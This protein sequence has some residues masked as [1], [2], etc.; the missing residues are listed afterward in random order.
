[1]WFSKKRKRLICRQKND[2]IRNGVLLQPFHIYGNIQREINKNLVALRSNVLAYPAG[3]HIVLYN[4]RTNVQHFIYKGSCETEVTAFN[5][6]N[7]SPYC[8]F[9]FALDNSSAISS[10]VKLFQNTRQFLGE[11]KHVHVG[12]RSKI[13]QLAFSASEKFVF[14][15]AENI[16]GEEY[17]VSVWSVETCRLLTSFIRT[18]PLKLLETYAYSKSGVIY[19]ANG[20]LYV[21]KY[22][23][24]LQK[25]IERILETAIK[26]EKVD[27]GENVKYKI[28][29]PEELSCFHINYKTDLLFK[30]YQTKVDIFIKTAFLQTVLVRPFIEIS[31]GKAIQDIKAEVVSVSSINNLA[32]IGLSEFSHL[33]IF[34]LT[35]NNVF[36][37]R[38]YIDL[39]IKGVFLRVLRIDVAEDLSTIGV[40]IWRQNTLGTTVWA[41]SKPTIEFFEVD[42]AI[43]E[44]INYSSTEALRPIYENGTFSGS[45]IDAGIAQNNDLIVCLGN[46]RLL[47]LFNYKNEEEELASLSLLRNGLCVDI[48]PTGLQLAVGFKEGLKVFSATI[49]E[50]RET[51]EKVGKECCCVRY[52]SRGDTLA[53]SS[54]GSVIIYDPFSMEQIISLVAHATSIKSMLWRGNDS[55]LLTSCM[56]GNLFVWQNLTWERDF[57]FY[58]ANKASAVTTI[59]YDTSLDL[60]VYATSN[61]KLHMFYDKGAVEI[62]HHEVA[63]LTI[64]CLLICRVLKVLFAGCSNGSVQMFIWPLCQNKGII[65]SITTLL[66]Q[67]PVTKLM[68]NGDRSVLT[69]CSE[70]ATVFVSKIHS[71]ADNFVEDKNEEQTKK[72]NSKDKESPLIDEHLADDNVLI[73][74]GNGLDDGDE[75]ER[76]EMRVF[77]FSELVITSSYADKRKQEILKDL[78]FQIQNLKNEIEEQKEILEREHKNL[79]KGE[80]ISRKDVLKDQKEML[81]QTIEAEEKKHHN[82]L[83]QKKIEIA[84]FEARQ[85]DMQEFHETEL[86][87]VY[88]E[89]D[90]LNSEYTQL[91][92]TLHVRSME[93]NKTHEEELGGV[94]RDSNIRTNNLKSKYNKTFENLQLNE[95]K[96]AE[97]LSQM[98]D[99][100]RLS[101]LLNKKK[102]EVALMAEKKKIEELKMMN[103]KFQKENVKYKDRKIQLDSLIQDSKMQNNQLLDEIKQLAES[104][105]MMQGKLMQQESIIKAKEDSLK[106]FR[107]KNEFLQSKKEVYDYLVV[108]L[109]VQQN[110]LVD[111]RTYLNMNLKKVHA[112]LI[113]EAENSKNL[114]IQREETHERVLFAK[115]HFKQSVLL[116]KNLRVLV[117]RIIVEVSGHINDNK[118]DHD[119]F[120]DSVIELLNSRQNQ[121]VL[122]QS[123]GVISEGVREG[124]YDQGILLNQIGGPS[125]PL[126]F[127]AV[128]LFRIEQRVPAS[129]TTN[130]RKNG[131]KFGGNSQQSPEEGFM[132]EL[133]KIKTNFHAKLKESESKYFGLTQEKQGVVRDIQNSGAKLIKQSN[134]L[135]NKRFGIFQELYEQKQEAENITKEIAS[136]NF[137]AAQK[138]YNEGLKFRLKE[139]QRREMVKLDKLNPTKFRSNNYS[140]TVTNLKD[141]KPQPDFKNILKEAFKWHKKSGE[142]RDV[143]LNDPY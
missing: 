4:R 43:L 119:M 10:T 123:K 45:I 19:E 12:L 38:N 42:C 90:S 2:T 25:L 113:N 84:T 61:M 18:G 140:R 115:T 98:E 120:K 52:S 54:G 41:D 3:H 16:E 87:K 7:K 134:Q 77:K 51:V 44:A 111:Y 116:F 26:L 63:P 27:S 74:D 67:L 72:L 49:G 96:F 103:G 142:T 5:I 137:R 56:T 114:K 60:L 81:S 48:H 101:F 122:K 132:N 23:R 15:Y 139:K 110:Q 79:R 108:S 53:A 91:I 88:Q 75:L 31:D 70:D 47:K 21:L 36:K 17:V 13:K 100:F 82:L 86:L 66:H 109:E 1:M 125:T 40:S 6:I 11:L 118:L 93:L 121:L 9:A 97:V 57:E 32:I 8:L 69:S 50:L 131:W 95:E 99:E 104:V 46:D 28:N 105:E 133:S 85:E 59:D 33:L 78:D 130:N 143:Y 124:E 89:H 112:S 73:F 37:F 20:S 92:E 80:E 62:V 106:D 102:L 128:K 129:M 127:K 83:E 39:A 94:A 138:K 35:P 29:N 34:N 141:S 30:G 65:E 126:E 76:D 135:R 107:H 117:S 58:P 68:I 136:L 22:K 71:F 14:T 24:K 64:N 55:K